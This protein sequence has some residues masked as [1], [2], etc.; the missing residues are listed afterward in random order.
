M[1]IYYKHKHEAA[2]EP[3]K[4]Y[5]HDACFDLYSI[6]NKMIH[7]YETIS[8][9]ISIRIPQE[10]VGLVCSRSGL[11]SK[12][13]VFV[14]NAPG[15]IDSGYHGEVK[16]VL[17]NLSHKPYKVKKGD[18]IAQLMIIPLWNVHL[19]RSDNM[20]WYSLRGDNGFGSSGD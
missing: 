13:G 19:L 4:A 8:T 3:T 11:A 12:N 14:L 15:I 18:R 5:E 17:G 9:G 16:V 2:I 10:F 6:E 1:L 20:V 7:D